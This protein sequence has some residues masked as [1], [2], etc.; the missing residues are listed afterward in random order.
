MTP[1]AIMRAAPPKPSKSRGVGPDVAVPPKPVLGA[2]N[3]MTGTV[4]RD[5]GC[6]VGVET[7]VVVVTGTVVVVTGTVEVD[8]VVDVVVTF[9]HAGTVIRLESRVTAPV[10]AST[11]PLTA[12]PVSRVTEV[13]ASIV[14][15]KELV[16]PRVAELVTCQNT[17][18]ADA[19]FSRTTEL[20][21]AV[22]RALGTW[23]MNTAF[24]SP[25]PFKVRVPVIPKLEGA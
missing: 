16:E 5:V 3:G 4:V 10:R 17:L 14:P 23:K 6:V 12:A 7:T 22:V 24:E 1:A 21:G 18:Q 20:P 11:R 19:P 2:P 15:A 8:V 9:E 13:C 25:P